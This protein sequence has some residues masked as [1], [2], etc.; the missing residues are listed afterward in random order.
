MSDSMGLHGLQHARLLCPSISPGVCSD[1]CPLSWWCYED[2]SCSPYPFSFCLQSFPALGSFPMSQL[3]ASAGQ[4][5]GAS[6]SAL[7]MNIQHWFPLGLTGL[8]SLLFKGFSRVFSSTTLQKHQFLCANLLYGPALTSIHDYWKKGGRR[9]GWQ[10]MR[11]LDG[12][13]SIDMSLSK[14]RGKPGV[15][16][17][18]GSQR[19]GH[20]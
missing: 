10:R 14:L 16:Q 20:N 3:F 12:I 2:I 8:I 1:S 7:P 18:M 6:T 11:W 13:N 19:V 15:L 4:N 9:R 17:S 5:V